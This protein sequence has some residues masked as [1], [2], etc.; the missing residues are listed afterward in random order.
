M[1]SFCSHALI[2]NNLKIVIRSNNSYFLIILYF[3]STHIF[4]STIQLY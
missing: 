1:F 2:S 4:Q 3:R